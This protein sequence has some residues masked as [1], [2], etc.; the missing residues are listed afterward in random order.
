MNDRTTLVSGCLFQ[1]SIS[2]AVMV[3]VGLLGYR[4]VAA[5]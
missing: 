1:A 4:I 5:W 3:V 2:G